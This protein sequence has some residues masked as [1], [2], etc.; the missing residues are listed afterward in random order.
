MRNQDA[1][2]S[3]SYSVE[4][5]QLEFNGTSID[6]RMRILNIK[7]TGTREYVCYDVLNQ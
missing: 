3:T 2:I 5:C 6:E 1:V 4:H 7:S